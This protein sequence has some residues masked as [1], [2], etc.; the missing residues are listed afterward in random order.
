MRALHV[1][2]VGPRKGV[3]LAC[4]PVSPLWDEIPRDCP[5]GCMRRCQLPEPGKPA[6]HEGI[7]GGDL[8]LSPVA[9]EEY[10]IQI[11]SSILLGLTCSKVL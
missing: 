11:M 3:K 7:E 4:G 6:M 8:R 10:T 1:A 5:L 2:T 9:M